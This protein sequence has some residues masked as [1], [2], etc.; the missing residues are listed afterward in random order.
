MTF[1]LIIA[2][3]LISIATIIFNDP[4]PPS[5]VQFDKP[6]I[7]DVSLPDQVITFPMQLKDDLEGL[8]RDIKQFFSPS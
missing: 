6:K 2:L 8:V 5:N 1:G 4:T 7:V 3:L